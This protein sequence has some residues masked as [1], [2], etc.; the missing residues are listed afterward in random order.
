[1]PKA[2]EMG[3]EKQLYAQVIRVLMEK[4]HIKKFKVTQDQLEDVADEITQVLWSPGGTLEITR[5]P[6]P[7][8]DES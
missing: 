4:H 8:I 6:Q 3:F 2:Y 7:P 5:I 1:M